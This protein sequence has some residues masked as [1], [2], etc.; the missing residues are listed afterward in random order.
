MAA[1]QPA[2]V[3]D[4]LVPEQTS[5][6]AAAE[7]EDYCKKNP[8]LCSPPK[9]EG[10]NGNASMMDKLKSF[11]SDADPDKDRQKKMAAAAGTFV[12]IA[13]AATGGYFLYKRYKK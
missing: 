6:M 9:K 12:L 7:A 2:N 1:E 13:A 3:P 10:S 8:A 5:K 11:V 4:T